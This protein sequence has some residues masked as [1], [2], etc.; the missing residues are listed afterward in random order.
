[1]GIKATFTRE[2]VAVHMM[3]RLQAIEKAVIF[4]L[5]YLGE[6]CVTTAR[7]NGDYTDHTGN[8]RNSIGYVI[9]QNGVIVDQNFKKSAS[10]KSSQEGPKKGLDLAMDVAK[11]FSKGYV[12]IVVAGMEYAT[13]VESAGRDVLVSAEY[14]AN[15]EMPKLLK[16]LKMK[17]G[18]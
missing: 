10:V 9:L 13:K 16:T 17:I 7:V 4:N 8:L 5:H 3:K 12:L 1:M 18:K 11:D 14:Y 6:Q 15:S 2:D